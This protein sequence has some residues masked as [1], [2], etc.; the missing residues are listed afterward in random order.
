MNGG[1]GVARH[2]RSLRRSRGHLIDT[3]DVYAQG[4]SEQI[5]GRWLASRSDLD[6]LVIATKAFFGLATTPRIGGRV[7]ATSRGH[8]TPASIVSGST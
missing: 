7:A 6:H 2:A 3:A 1:G 4:R 8:W 5:I